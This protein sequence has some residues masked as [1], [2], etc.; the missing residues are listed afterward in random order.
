MRVL[1]HVVDTRG[2]P[3]DL[4][5]VEQTCERCKHVVDAMKYLQSML[6]QI[7]VVE[8]EDALNVLVRREAQ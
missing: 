7:Q 6:P 3:L 4:A 5:L 1:S 2:A 8:A